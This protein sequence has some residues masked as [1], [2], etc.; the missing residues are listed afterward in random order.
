[1]QAVPAAQYQKNKQINQTRAEDLNRQF[2]KE[3]IEI[4]RKQTHEKMFSITC[5]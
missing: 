4:D 5:Y 2:S 1:M 3:D